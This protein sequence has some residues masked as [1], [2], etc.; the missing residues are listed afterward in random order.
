V[1]VSITG[2][3]PKRGSRTSVS[4][5]RPSGCIEAGHVR[6][7]AAGRGRNSKLPWFLLGRSLWWCVVVG[8]SEA[9]GS[10][11]EWF[12]EEGRSFVSLLILKDGVRASTISP[13]PRPRMQAPRASS[14][15]RD[16]RPQTISLC[17]RPASVTPPPQDNLAL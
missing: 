2:G 6:G 16:A 13:C 3:A 11:R 17:A 5:G 4:I 10:G 7:G 8:D 12:V 1:R 14:S 9:V 15:A